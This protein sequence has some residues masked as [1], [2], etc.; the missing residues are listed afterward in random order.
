M[1]PHIL[2]KVILSPGSRFFWRDTAGFSETSLLLGFSDQVRATF[3][4]IK[5]P[6][7]P[8]RGGTG[9]SG[10]RLGRDDVLFPGKPRGGPMEVVVLPAFST[11]RTWWGADSSWCLQIQVSSM[12]PRPLP[13]RLC[14]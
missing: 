12:C 1:T 10:S 9:H 6:R 7:D 3:G 11:G 8:G 4:Y 5:Q 14:T 13:G 2:T